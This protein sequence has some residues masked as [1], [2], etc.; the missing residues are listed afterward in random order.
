[1]C[2]CTTLPTLTPACQVTS[3]PYLFFVFFL[4]V[5]VCFGGGRS[6]GVQVW[7]E[8]Q[9]V[10]AF[11]CLSVCVC[12]YEGLCVCVYSKRMFVDACVSSYFRHSHHGGLFLV[13][14]DF[15]CV[16]ICTWL[17]GFVHIMLACVCVCCVCMHVCFLA[18][19]RRA[20]LGG[21]GK[22]VCSGPLVW[23]SS[24]SCASPGERQFNLEEQGS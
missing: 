6:I 5:A 1:M 23:K 17:W 21:C 3:C 13:L 12:V 16:W 24:Q 10:F 11:C 19:D 15:V 7:R 18:V 9:S 20:G 22:F 4:L 8:Q 2:A 14:K